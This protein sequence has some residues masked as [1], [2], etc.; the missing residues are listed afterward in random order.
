MDEVLNRYRE[1]SC[2]TIYHATLTVTSF[3][4][5]DKIELGSKRL[6]NLFLVKAIEKHFPVVQLAMLFNLL[7]Q[8][9]FVH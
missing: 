5:M 4:S 7:L 3:N 9:E 6:S 1:Y 8:F 2:G